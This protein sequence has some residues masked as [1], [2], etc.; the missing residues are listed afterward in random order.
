MVKRR[1]ETTTGALVLAVNIPK[2]LYIYHFAN[3]I[4]KEQT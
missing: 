3:K 4:V 1:Y 2:L